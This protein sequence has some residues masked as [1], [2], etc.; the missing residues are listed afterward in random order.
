MKKIVLILI[1]FVLIFS[2]AFSTVAY[3]EPRRANPIISSKSASIL[4]DDSGKITIHFTVSAKGTCSTLGV[5]S[6]SLYNSD[7]T[8]L[9]TYYSSAYANMLGSNVSYHSGTVTYPGKVGQSYYA[10]V[11]FYAVYNG[12]TAS[13][14][15]TVVG[16]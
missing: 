14:G 1:A 9:K 4:V 15:T 11:N 10:V 7:G 8:L 5:S 13:T 3:A 16:P 12:S 2:F 6:I